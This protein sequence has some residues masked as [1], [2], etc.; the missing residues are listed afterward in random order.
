MRNFI[1]LFIPG[2]VLSSLGLRASGLAFL[3]YVQ[4]SPTSLYELGA[5]PYGFDPT[6]RRDR[7]T[8]QVAGTRRGDK[9]LRQAHTNILA[10]GS[11][12]KAQRGPKI[13]QIET[14]EQSNNINP[15]ITQISQIN[16]KI[17]FNS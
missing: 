4:T 14:D 16:K 11:K 13:T 5:S 8:L 15:Q 12:L 2:F 3:S 7:S 1:G 17:R 10:E 6:R 9:M